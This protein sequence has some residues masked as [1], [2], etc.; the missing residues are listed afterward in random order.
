MGKYI[1]CLSGERN[2]C[3]NQVVTAATFVS[4]QAKQTFNI[5][6]NVNCKSKY[7]FHLPEGIYTRWNIQYVGKTDI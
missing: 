6:F 4:Q 7:V 2:L 1:P 5:F 3:C